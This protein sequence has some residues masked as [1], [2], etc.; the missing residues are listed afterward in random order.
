MGFSIE[1]LRGFCIPTA[2]IA[3]LE[4]STKYQGLSPQRLNHYVSIGRP[5]SLHSEGKHIS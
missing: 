2:T 5:I 3:E 4:H 1:A